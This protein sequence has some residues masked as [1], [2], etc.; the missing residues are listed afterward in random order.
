MIRPDRRGEVRDPMAYVVLAII[1]ILLVAA[2]IWYYLSLGEELQ[3]RYGTASGQ[4]GHISV[5]G[6]GILGGMFKQAGHRVSSWPRLSPALWERAD[7]IVWF[8][9]DVQKPSDDVIQWLGDWL[10]DEPGRTLI[11]VGRDFDAEPGYWNKVAPG[12]PVAVAPEF[13]RRQTKAASDFSITRTPLPASEDWTWFTMEGTLKQRSVTTLAGALRW[14]AGVD[15]SKVEIELHGRL[16]PPED[17]FGDPDEVLLESEGDAL[18][19]SEKYLSR[20]P[21]SDRHSQVIVVVNGSFLLNFQLVNHE[22]RKLA[23]ALVREIGPNQ[24]VVFLEA[25]GSPTVSDKDPQARFPTA[26]QLLGIAPFNR[27]LLHL[28]LVGIIFCFSRWPI[29]GRPREAPAA[30]LSD[31]GEHVS[32][33]GEL[34]ALA[35]NRE[36]ALARLQHYH[37]TQRPEAR[38]QKPPAPAAPQPGNA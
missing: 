6:A 16:I 9:D 8:P 36:L 35:G 11:Y 30:P 18:V 1:A 37:Q 12:A 13:A 29:F 33:L 31:F 2:G 10:F 14:L 26:A 7:T 22:H 34:L 38:G 32:S 25:S 24:H 21:N 23:A 28:A 20:A 5:N 4:Y 3:T 15:P 27:I 19:W 17:R